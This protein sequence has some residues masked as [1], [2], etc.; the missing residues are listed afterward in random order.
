MS[1]G[2]QARNSEFLPIVL[3]GLVVSI[4]MSHTQ[5]VTLQEHELD[6]HLDHGLLYVVNEIF[7]IR[8]DR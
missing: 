6:T 1:K 3:A 4:P 8:S 7:I 5:E 2:Y